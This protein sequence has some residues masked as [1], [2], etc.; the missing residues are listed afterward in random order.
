MRRIIYILLGIVAVVIALIVI[1]PF[2]IPVDAYRSR[3]EAEATAATGR[4]L[5]IDGPLKLTV[6]PEL[7]LEAKEVTLGNAPGGHAR[8]FVSMDS[9]RVGV[10]LVPLL[11]GKFEFS[12]V[13]LE[14]PVINLEATKHGTD[15]WVL[16]SASTAKHPSSRE[17]ANGGGSAAARASF[18]GVRIVDGRIN[19]RDDAAPRTRTIENINLMIGVTSLNAPVTL[20]G[21]LK[22]GGQKI[23]LKGRISSPDALMMGKATPVDLSLTSSLMQASF[24]GVLART[25]AHGALKL[26]TPS[27][28]KLAAWAG[29]PL[30][31][32]GG[33]GHL[34]LEGRLSA[35]GK[36]DSF[37]GIKLVLDKMTLT[38]ALTLNRSSRMPLVSGRL[39]VD[40]LNFNPYLTSSF[41]KA[42]ADSSAH[43]ASAQGWSTSPLNLAVLKAMNAQLTLKVGSLELRK[44]KVGKTTLAVDLRGGVLKARFDRMTLYGGSGTGTLDVDA[45]G[46][47]PKLTDS[48]RLQGLSLKNF[49]NDTLGI[50]RIEGTGALTLDVT[51]SGRSPNAIMHA[52]DGKGA[53][54]FVD[55]RIHGVDL[56][57]VASTVHS[58]LSAQTTSS[59]ASTEFTEMG[60]TFTVANGVM[61]SKDFHLLSPFIRMTGAGNINLG[62]QTIDFVV[63]PKAVA[64][65]P[66]QG[67]SQNA[68]G[69]GIPFRIHGPWKD[70]HYTPDLTGVATDIIGSVKNGNF[71]TK[72]VVKGLLGGLQ[73]GDQ[74]QQA[75]T[76]QP[77]QNKQSPI[78]ALK[79]LFG[80]H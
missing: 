21:S 52:L 67:G 6:F 17:G 56:A 41:A 50:S 23:S 40:D 64:S 33:L 79:S 69:I 42:K 51:A 74:Q 39:A 68:A 32:G 43:S 76:P 66:G 7:G 4:Q 65:L 25:T 46:T 15:N 36:V 72:S 18:Q 48:V 27:L 10:K 11:S 57:G 77:K 53:I 49:L 55:G 9:L 24:K 13:T 44:L 73:Q 5:K 78:N 45:S 30:A 38:G 62:A 37:S 16:G 1:L 14:R 61:T 58:A 3:I 47:M 26:D 59:G 80:R 28:R 34:S 70:I 20:D 22:T 71:S 19:Y 54:K 8:Y 31:P 63:E 75:G 60:G 29:E 35:R 12:Q 2:V